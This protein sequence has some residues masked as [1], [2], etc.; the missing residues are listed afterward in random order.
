MSSIYM[1]YGLKLIILLL[2]TWMI[3]QCRRDWITRRKRTWFKFVIDRGSIDIWSRRIAFQSCCYWGTQ[4]KIDWPKQVWL[5]YKLWR[6]RP[7]PSVSQPFANQTQSLLS[8]S[9]NCFWLTAWSGPV[10]DHM[11]QNECYV[12]AFRESF[13]Q[14][15]HPSSTD[16]KRS[17]EVHSN[18]CWDESEGG[19]AADQMWLK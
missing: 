17:D 7:S 19:A 5:Q 18:L 6:R 4:K 2:L 3:W 1:V 15:I 11:V 10:V 9:I 13:D 8:S 16:I 14:S 12:N